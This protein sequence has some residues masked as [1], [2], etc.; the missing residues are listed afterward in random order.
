MSTPICLLG[1]S[2]VTQ[3]LGICERTLEKLVRARKFPPGLK[4][5]K[6]VV[7]A[8]AV[9][10]QWLTD[11]LGAQMNWQPPQRTRKAVRPA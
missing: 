6:H 9:V 11:A 8:D 7:W 1:K 5:G 4:I 10:E 2:D 3:R